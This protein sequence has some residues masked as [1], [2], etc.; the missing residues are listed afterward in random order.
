MRRLWRA[1]HRYGFVVENAR[2]YRP[3]QLAPLV[4]IRSSDARRLSKQVPAIVDRLDPRQAGWIGWA[5]EGFY[6][7]GRDAGEVPRMAVFVTWR[8]RPRGGGQ[9]AQS[10]DLFPYPHG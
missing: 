6:L 10:D 8:G 7:E 3:F 2:L 4:V 5:Y 1:S 9:W